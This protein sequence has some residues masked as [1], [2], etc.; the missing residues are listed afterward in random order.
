[1]NSEIKMLEKISDFYAKGD[2]MDEL[3]VDREVELI[4]QTIPSDPTSAGKSIEIGCGN[5]YSTERLLPLF[6][7]LKVVEPS[8]NNINLML[9]RIK[10]DIPHE[11]SLLEDYNTDEKFDQVI[12]LHVLEHVAD[13][14][15]SLKKIESLLT[16][17]GR[18]FISVPNCMSLNRR[19][20]YKMGLLKSYD[21]MAPKD[22]ELGHR[23]LY[24]VQMLTDHI[25]SCGLRV[26]SMKGIF[27]KSLSETQMMGLGMDA[28]RAFYQ[29]GDD[30]PHYCANLFA[31][32]RKRYY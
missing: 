22:Y 5:G 23:R 12:F 11:I 30:I 13:P 2:L 29:I 14:F 4:K 25:E 9:N 27:L 24:T 28:I 16:D 3:L 6:E 1:M 15:A 32:V 17:E 20:G 21:T 7:N 26:E 10:K 8:K 18:A 19:A 31:V